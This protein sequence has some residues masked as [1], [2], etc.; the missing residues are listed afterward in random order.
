LPE[1]PLARV[2]HFTRA[3]RPD[4]SSPETWRF[5]TLQE[6]R[7]GEEKGGRGESAWKRERGGNRKTQVQKAN[8]DWI[9]AKALFEPGILCLE[10]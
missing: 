6:R 9:R 1:G 10:D 3:G 4:R 8:L 5:K 7:A 2:Y